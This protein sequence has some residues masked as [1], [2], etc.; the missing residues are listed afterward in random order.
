MA[1]ESAASCC[2]PTCAEFEA[3]KQRRVGTRQMPAANVPNSPKVQ[4]P[5]FALKE[6]GE[7][8]ECRG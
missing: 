4:S 1:E 2:S 3:G 5:V 7:W 8:A 6:N